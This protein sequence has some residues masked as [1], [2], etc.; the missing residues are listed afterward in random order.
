MTTD[1]LINL[2]TKYGIPSA[3]AEAMALFLFFIAILLFAAIITRVVKKT[4]I[5]GIVHWL[6]KKNYAWATPLV[7][8]NFFS[9][10]IWFIPLALLVMAVDSLLPKEATLYLPAQRLIM[11]GFVIISVMCISALLTSVLEINFLIRKKRG[12][13]LQGYVDALRIITYVLA[14][15]FI[16]SIFTGR[17]PWGI[18]S[19]LGG[20]TAVIL[21]IFKDSIL[22]F[23]ASIQIST[24]DLVR[25]GDW[26]EMDQ[27]G[28]D[29]D[30][31]SISI[32]TVKVQ[33]FDKT[34]TTIPTYS[35]VSSSFKNW[36]GMQNSEGRRIKRSLYIDLNSIRFCDDQLLAKFS[37]IAILKEYIEEKQQEITKSNEGIPADSPV[38]LNGRRQTNI[39]VFR[40]YVAAYLKN[41]SNINK[42]M[43]FLVRQLAPT[44]RG[45]PL[46]LYVFSKDQ[47]W[48]NYEA[49][50]A[51]IFD[52]LIAA[53][54]EF[55]LRLY[56]LPS[57]YDLRA[58][59][60]KALT[61]TLPV[62]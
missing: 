35:L 58:V 21:L 10:V 25:V 46:E 62:E 56:Q 13:M 6:E 51:D 4:L 1:W 19:V 23:I 54:P 36:R 42:Q 8:N 61:S 15:I 18:L 9:R 24:L 5:S 30:V 20:L 60:L 34:I 50:Q 49:I 44:D 41:N 37:K 27:Y 47:V 28:A 40:A 16:I 11:T 12:A 57:G 39:G 14:A 17:S 38:F 33:N 7:Q 43:T 45:L 32:H 29:G 2:L 48:A 22:G 55:D 53:A 31:I 59:N 3:A 26:I 52:H